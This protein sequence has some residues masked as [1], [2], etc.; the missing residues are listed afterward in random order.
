MQTSDYITKDIKPLSSS[1]K[2]SKAKELFKQLTFSHL[3]VVDK[4]VFLGLIAENDIQAVVDNNDLLSEYTYLLQPFSV[5]DK[6]NWFELL[7]VFALNDANIIPVLTEKQ[8]YLGYYELT[9]I[10]HIFNSTPF[11]NESGAILVISKEISDYSFSE[12][13]QIVESNNA[14]LLG[15]FISNIDKERVEVTVKISDHD[16]NNT[17]QTFRRYNYTILTGFQVDEYLNTLK[18][19]SDYLQKYL[20]I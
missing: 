7:K 15:A 16:L 19:R 18:E 5:T 8:K 12:I 17:M 11:L 10:L 2:A 9:D 6:T 13:S 20:D 4:G 3:P 1:D 14:K